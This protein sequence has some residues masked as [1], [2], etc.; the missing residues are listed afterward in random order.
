M[1]AVLV[2]AVAI[3]SILLCTPV[4][5]DQELTA[6]QLL[7]DKRLRYSA[8]EFDDLLRRSDVLVV[9]QPELIEY[10]TIVLERLFPEN[11]GEFT[12][13]L[14]K[15]SSAN[16]FVLPN[17]SMYINIGMLARLT[18][19]AQLAMVLAHEGQ[20]YI[21]HHGVHSIMRARA[22]S[23]VGTVVGAVLG[24]PVAGALLAGSSFAGFSK[25][26][27]RDADKLGFA[28]VQAAGYQVSAAAK[29]FERMAA[30]ANASE[31]K[32]GGGMFDSH[33]RLSERVTTLSHLAA[34]GPTDGETQRNRF[35]EVTADARL[36]ALADQLR[37][38]RYAELVVLLEDGEILE[39]FPSFARYYLA[40][41][42]QMRNQD[43]DAEA[44]AENF[45]RVTLTAP[46]FALGWRGL[47]LYLMRRGGDS[48]GAIE[49][50][51]RFLELEPDANDR[52]FIEHY[53]S[54]LH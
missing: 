11:A 52:A 54:T 46:D 1:K 18:D 51:R 9:D 44:A 45:R 36:A 43:G 34:T 21:R 12:V 5:A 53:I 3:A 49:A 13:Y 25:D 37:R 16:A 29:P 23:A 50:F 22:D 33:P 30:E 17:G 14:H 28:R 6:R 32:T 15:N 2:F 24:V 47:G 38:R 42:L 48:E 10:L 41:A 40:E 27:E 35:M 31:R 20:H 8:A 4:G 39:S 7:Q 19:E 26:L